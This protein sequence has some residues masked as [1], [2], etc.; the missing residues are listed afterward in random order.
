MMAECIA[1]AVRL[2]VTVP[3]TIDERIDVARRVGE[4]KTSMLQDLEA[5]RALELGAIVGCVVELGRRLAI[6]TPATQSIYALTRLL[7][8]SQCASGER[9]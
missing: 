3:A 7:E 1:I 6:A 4:H 8:R 2:G 9:R 5:G